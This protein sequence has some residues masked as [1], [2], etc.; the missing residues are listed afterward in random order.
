M[1]AKSDSLYYY[2]CYIDLNEVEKILFSRNLSQPTY[3]IIHGNILD[4]C[5]TN[6]PQTHYFFYPEFLKFVFSLYLAVL[7]SCALGF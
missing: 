5:I 4:L 2:N 6:I 3:I 7:C 1:K